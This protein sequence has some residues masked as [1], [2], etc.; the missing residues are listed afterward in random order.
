MI[1]GKRQIWTEHV[2]HDDTNIRPNIQHGSWASAEPR[3]ANNGT[4]LR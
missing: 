1:T 4:H 3:K 2:T